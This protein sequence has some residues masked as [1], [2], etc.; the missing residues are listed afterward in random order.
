MFREVEVPPDSAKYAS[1]ANLVA[2][3][4]EDAILWPYHLPEVLQLPIRALPRDIA[5]QLASYRS[6]KKKI[7]RENEWKYM[8]SNK[9]E[10]RKNLWCVSET[11]ELDKT[12][13]TKKVQSFV[14]ISKLGQTLKKTFQTSES[15]TG[16][17]ILFQFFFMYIHVDTFVYKYKKYVAS[18]TGA[19]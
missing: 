2:P 10:N 3:G 11:L 12:R 15:Y 6:V 5:K 18:K 8:K 19:S 17:L 14:F 7:D 1:V 16:Y 4:K 13:M 9:Y